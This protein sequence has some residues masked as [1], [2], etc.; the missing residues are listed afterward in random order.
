MFSIAHVLL[1]ALL[2]LL[3]IPSKLGLVGLQVLGPILYHY[4]LS[5]GFVV[6]FH[7]VV[8]TVSMVADVGKMVPAA[9]PAL[10]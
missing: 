5:L 8:V 3:D 10:K 7:S 6:D 1:L 9:I 4:S 2:C